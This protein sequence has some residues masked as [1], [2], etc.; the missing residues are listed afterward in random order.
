MYLLG[1]RLAKIGEA[2]LEGPGAERLPPA[3]ALV[4]GDVLMHPDS[5]ISEI[6]ARTG[7]PQGYVSKSVN[8]LREWGVVE[9]AT[10]PADGRR[11]LVRATRT[12][13]TRIE[14]R[15][16]APVDAVLA[17][18]LDTADSQ[19]V[20]EVRAALELLVDRLVPKGARTR[21]PALH[22]DRAGVRR[23]SG[24]SSA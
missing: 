9:T 24:G 2:A 1:R 20:A 15:A 23:P 14:E 17:G 13:P 3:L 22:A 10:D 19:V 11:T 12:V 16:K 4:L 7:Y 21:S 18:A 5:S 8:R 6:T